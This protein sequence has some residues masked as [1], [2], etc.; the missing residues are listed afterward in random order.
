MEV[1]FCECIKS[2]VADADVERL[3]SLLPRDLPAEEEITKQKSN[4]TFQK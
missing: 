1:C 2:F 3:E 4:Y